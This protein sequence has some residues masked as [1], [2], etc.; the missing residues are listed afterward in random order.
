[1]KVHI[2]K[3]TVSKPYKTTGVQISID[4]GELA[5]SRIYHM[6]SK[7]LGFVFVESVRYKYSEI[8]HP[9]I[10]RCGG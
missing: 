8:I 10:S 9:T 4:L 5:K 6:L 2:D 1:M 3:N 7:E